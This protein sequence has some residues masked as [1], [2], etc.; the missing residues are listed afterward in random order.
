MN[1]LLFAPGLLVLLLLRHGGLKTTLYLMLCAI[2]QVSAIDRH[3]RVCYLPVLLLPV[4]LLF[5][6]IAITYLYCRYPPVFLLPTCISVAYL[7]CCY[8]PIL[9][10]PTCIA[11]TYLY[12]CYLPVL[13]LPTCIAVTCIVVAC[14]AVTCI[15][16]T[17]THR[18]RHAEIFGWAKS[19]ANGSRTTNDLYATTL[20]SATNRKHC[21][22]CVKFNEEWKTM[23]IW[24]TAA[25]EIFYS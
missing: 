20:G 18:G 9:L 11:V 2:V 25:I 3:A 22:M 21:V 23:H 19:A 1:V 14:I 17:C 12:C 5:T 6:Y 8:L 13:L 7:Y 10:L 4:L 24:L 16:V 15:A